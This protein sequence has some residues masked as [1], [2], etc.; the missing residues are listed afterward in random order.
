MPGGACL[1][2]GKGGG[3]CERESLA[4]A[5]AETACMTRSLKELLA[6]L[7]PLADA[8]QRRAGASRSLPSHR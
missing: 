2:A 4:E 1:R 7:A 8:S 5:A 3:R 6:A